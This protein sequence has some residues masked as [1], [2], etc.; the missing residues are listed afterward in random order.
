MTSVDVFRRTRIVA[1]R[2]VDALG[3]VNNTVWVRFVVALAE[4]HSSARGFDSRTVRSLGGQWIVRRHEIDYHAPA[5]PGEEIAEETWVA[6][7]KGARSI[8]HSRFTRPRDGILL[9]S[10]ITHW[11]YTSADTHRP[12]RIDP[13]ILA[14]FSGA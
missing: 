4:A 5:L 12:R 8:R 3:H 13:R 14:A 10:A 9:T 6:Q 11:A 7:M 1:D 2:D